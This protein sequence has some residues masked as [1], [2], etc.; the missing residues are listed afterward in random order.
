MNQNQTIGPINIVYAEILQS[1]TTDTTDNI[2]LDIG[3]NF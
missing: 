2:Y 1:E 3:Y